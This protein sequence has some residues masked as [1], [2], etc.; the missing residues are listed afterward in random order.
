VQYD[1]LGKEDHPNTTINV[2][3]MCGEIDCL[4]I[5][6]CDVNTNVKVSLSDLS[7]QKT[8]AN[9]KVTCDLTTVDVETMIVEDASDASMH[10]RQC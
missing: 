2:Q 8:D 4:D 10:F 3:S 9:E 7:Q 1:A 5:T 6:Q